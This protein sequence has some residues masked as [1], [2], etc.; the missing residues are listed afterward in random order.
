MPVLRVVNTP[1][2]DTIFVEF[3]FFDSMLTDLIVTELDIFVVFS[4]EKFPLVQLRIPPPIFKLVVLVVVAWILVKLAT[5][6]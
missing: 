4:V 1:T 3:M 2:D 6:A 5:V